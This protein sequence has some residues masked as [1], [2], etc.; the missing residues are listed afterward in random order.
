MNICLQHTTMQ[1]INQILRTVLHSRQ[2][3]QPSI[4][5]SLWLSFNNAMNIYPSCH[6]IAKSCEYFPR[7]VYVGTRMQNKSIFTALS[8]DGFVHSNMCF[9]LNNYSSL[10]SRMF[11]VTISFLQVLYHYV[12]ILSANQECTKSKQRKTDRI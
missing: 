4:S 7:W 2:T 12:G 5:Q 11:L 1:S 10:L 9:I 3:Q 8:T 6:Q